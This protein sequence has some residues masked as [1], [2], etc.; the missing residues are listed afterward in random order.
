MASRRIA[1]VL[2]KMSAPAHVLVLY[3][4]S[5]DGDQALKQAFELV[6]AAGSRLTVLAVA[7]VERVKGRCCGIQSPYWNGVMSELADE[8]LRR[9][10][11]VLDGAPGVRFERV[12]DRSVTSALAREAA[13][14]G[15]DMIVI[16][17]RRHRWAPYGTRRVSRRAIRRMGCDLVELPAATAAAT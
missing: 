15:C 3:T 12:C 14:R 2:Q 5:V 9:A 17:R 16:P 6:Q 4:A 1:L 8:D 7:V 10:T 13:E 11:Q